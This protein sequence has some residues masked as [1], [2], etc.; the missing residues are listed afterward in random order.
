MIT[1]ENILNKYL[2]T[3]LD[4]KTQPTYCASKLYVTGQI[5]SCN[6]IYITK[7]TSQKESWS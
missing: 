6:N 1:V 2:I 7:V 4:L 3:L 5:F